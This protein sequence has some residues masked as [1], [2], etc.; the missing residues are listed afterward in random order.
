MTLRIRE[1]PLESIAHPRNWRWK[2]LPDNQ[3][4]C[5][6]KSLSAQIS[7]E[8]FDHPNAFFGKISGITVQQSS[9]EGSKPTM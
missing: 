8:A 6:T 2:P 3:A 4:K 7:A 1:T 9:G 5:L